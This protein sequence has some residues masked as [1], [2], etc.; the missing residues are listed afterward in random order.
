MKLFLA[1]AVPVCLHVVI[2]PAVN[3]QEKISKEKAPKYSSPI[4]T[5]ETDGNS[6]PIELDIT[7]A[8]SLLLEVNDGGDGSGYDWADWM[9]PRLIGPAGEKKLTELKWKKLEGRAMVNKNQGGGPLKVDAKDVPYG[10][11]THANSKIVYEL[12]EGYTKFVARGGLDNGGTDQKGSRTSVVF[13]AFTSPDE[14]F[15]TPVNLKSPEGFV[16][17]RVFA[18][19]VASIGSWVALGVD[20]KGRLLSA[21]RQGPL[22]R[23]TLPSDNDEVKVEALPVEVGGANGMLQAFGSF[24][25]TAKGRGAR[26]GKDGLYR[27]TDTNGDDH[28]DKVDFLI[29]LQVGSDHHAH[30]IIFNPD[31]TRLMILCGNSTDPPK[32]IATR[33][34]RHQA[35]DHL[36]PRST[37]YGHNTGREAPG[38]Y[39]ITCKPDGSDVHFLCAGFRNPYD[40]ALNAD[41]ELFTF[42]ADMEYDVGGPWYRPTRVNHCVSGGEYGWRWGAGKWPDWY[43]DTNGTTVDI[44]RGSPT[45]VVF[46]YGAKFPAKYQRAFF[47]CDWTYGRIVAVHMTES[48]STYEGTFEDFVYGPSNPVSDIVIHPDGAMYFV[49]GGRRNPTSLYKVTYQGDEPT[50]PISMDSPDTKGKQ[51]RA[52]RRQLEARHAP[53]NEADANPRSIDLAWQH[54]S[55]GDRGIRFAARTILEHHPTGQ[56][57]LKALSENDPVKTIESMIALARTGDSGQKEAIL[58]RLNRIDFGL[59]KLEQQLDILRAYGLVFIR[60][61]GPDESTSKHLIGTLEPLYPSGTVSLDHELCQMLLYLNAPGAVSSSV[62]QLK[63]AQTQSEQMFYAYHL[64]TIKDG[65]SDDD[66]RDYFGWIRFSQAHSGDYIGGGHFTNFLKMLDK[67][68]K[69][70]LSDEQKQ[71]LESIEVPEPTPPE[72]VDLGERPFVKNWTLDEMQPHLSVADTGRSFI[73]GRHL[74]NGLCAKCHLMKGQG[75]ALGPDLTS[76]GKKLAHPALLTEILEPSKVI[77][78]QHASVVLELKNGKVLT[79]REVGGD[80]E[81]ILL[82]TNAD[83][84]TKTTEVKRSAVENRR[85][86]PVSLMPR[87]LLNTLSAEEILDVLM[88]VSSGGDRG[89]RAFQQ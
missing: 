51:L 82:V 66:L 59:L 33:H 29:P 61:G 79:G 25:V 7:G 64:R 81:S 84:P 10:I 34:I 20:D 60:M 45:G 5:Q 19:S 62:A 4:V 75:G 14:D 46:G 69:A 63:A 21:D 70:R 54:I 26:K 22:Y 3:G 16:V 38:G 13:R 71:V 65:W 41:G 23:I 47:C 8:K 55:N 53:M 76:T 50:T 32:E 15:E 30:A 37:Y 18:D 17:E 6:V 42:D 40:I 35:E 56:W 11:G 12:P 58:N 57:Q 28:Y 2:A 72:A 74:Y 1:F 83:E 68:A 80:D 78:D 43:P 39:V 24:Y 49:T 48:G 89:H 67:E 77:S 86:S 85:L 73:R 88:Y 31:K 9:E 36:L 27:L 52:L 44:G 87:G